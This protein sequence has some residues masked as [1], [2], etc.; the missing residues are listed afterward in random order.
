VLEDEVSAVA[1]PVELAPAAF[2][3]V[4][5]E[6]E[7]DVAVV[8]VTAGRFSVDEL[9]VVGVELAAQP[10]HATTIDAATAAA[11]AIPGLRIAARSARA[12]PS[13]RW[14][15][16]R[17]CCRSHRL[18]DQDLGFLVGARAVLHSLRDDE[19]LAGVQLHLAVAQGDHEATLQHEEEIIGV[20]M[21]V[22]DE[23]TARPGQDDLVV[24]VLG[25]ELRLV[26]TS[27]IRAN[28]SARFTLSIVLLSG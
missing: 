6:V 20:V 7:A 8:S 15:R 9:P 2:V 5:V 3:D 23:L 4:S 1:V 19:Q 18:H 16:R 22:P 26:E 13:C 24:V 12:P 25:D 14:V 21:F 17:R 10:E 11:A 28:F 27:S